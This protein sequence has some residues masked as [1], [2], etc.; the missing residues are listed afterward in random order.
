MIVM[1]IE[2]TAH[3]F[4]VGIIDGEGNILADVRSRYTPP[5]GMGIEPFNAAEHHSKEAV[6]VFR[7]A[8][9]EAGIGVEDI[10]VIAFSRGPGLGPCLRVGASLARYLALRH[11]KPLYPVH[12]GVGHLELVTHYYSLRNPLHLLV[13][14]GHTS[15]LVLNECRYRVFGETLDITIGNLLD[16]LAR[17]AGLDFP[18]GPV[19]ESLAEGGGELLDLPYTIIGTSFQF[20]GI[21]TK[22][23]Q[24]LR[25]H[26]IEDVAYSVQEVAFSI[27]VEAVERALR[28]VPFDVDGIAISGGV[29]SNDTLYKKLGVMAERYGLKVYRLP[30]RLNGD[31]GV[32]IAVVGLRMALAGV[33]PPDLS[34]TGVVQRWRIDEVDIPWAC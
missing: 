26:R 19:I 15:I 27:I 2:S 10:D 16:V 22:A 30:K 6:N 11:G 7:K 29:A 21:L 13:S 32:Q 17:E 34:S 9:S 14:G 25:S 12:H 24:L 23:I 18:G 4:G 1:G 5:R 33:E 31:N 28:A 20:S 3:T 8:L